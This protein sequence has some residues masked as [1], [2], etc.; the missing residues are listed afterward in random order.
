MT[1][2]INTCIQAQDEKYLITTWLSNNIG[3]CDVLC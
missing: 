1:M 3:T 2:Y